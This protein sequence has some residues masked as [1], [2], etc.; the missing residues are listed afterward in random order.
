MNRERKREKE[1]E[2]DRIEWREREKEGERDE[3]R[4]R[5]REREG[6]CY[7]EGGSAVDTADEMTARQENYSDLMR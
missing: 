4:E 5:E 7:L 3:W 6:Q 2:R 1:G